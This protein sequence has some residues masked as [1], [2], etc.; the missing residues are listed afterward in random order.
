MKREDGFTVVEL[1]IFFVILAVLT[2]FFVVQKMD[3]DASYTDQ[4]RK[5]AIN[6]MYYS[7]NDVYFKENGHFPLAID[8]NTLKAIDPELLNDPWG[9]PIGDPDSDYQYEGLNCDSEGRCQQFKLTA[10]L[11]KEDDYVIESN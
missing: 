8:E 7:L 1:I 10:D 9:I 2:V 4:T 3:L 6:A 5:T 11:E